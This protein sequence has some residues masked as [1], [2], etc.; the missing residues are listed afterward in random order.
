MVEKR[1]VLIIEPYYGGSHKSFIEQLVRLSFA[2]EVMALPARKWKWRMR[3]SAPYFADELKKT[4][5]RFDRIIC[6]T[7]LDVATFRGMAPD[8]VRKV[9]LLTYF[10]E[11]QFAYPVQ[12]EDERDFHFALT[13]MTSALASDSLAFNSEYNLRTF[14]EGLTGLLKHSTDMRLEKHIEAIRTR[15]RVIPLGLDFTA[16]DAAEDPGRDGPPTVVWNHRWEHDKNPELFFETLFKLD[17]DG[18]DFRLL[19]LGQS[20]ERQPEIFEEAREKLK[21]KIVH[22]GFADTRLEYARWLKRGDLV[23]STSGHEFFGV[24][25]LEA[26]RAGCR[27]LLPKRLSYREMFPEEFLY[28]DEGFARRFKEELLRGGRLS[29]EMSIRLTEPYSWNKVAPL[30]EAWIKNARTLDDTVDIA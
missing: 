18:V 5:Q 17:S 15:S 28:E 12:A 30:Y 3:L 25:V 11:N 7:F 21:H 2:F 4:G 16:I 14:T 8:W 6:S 9:P 26:V 23:V 19:V 22:F 13:N 29:S 1:N 27:P 20:F 24:S 10:H